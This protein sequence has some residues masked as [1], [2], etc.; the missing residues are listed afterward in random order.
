[1]RSARFLALAI[2]LASSLFA[3]VAASTEGTVAAGRPWQPG[4]SLCV[5]LGPGDF[6]P[7]AG[8]AIAAPEDNDDGAG[9]HYCLYTP[10]R[11][12]IKGGIEFDAFVGA[13][14]ETTYATVI[15]ETGRGVD[16]RLPGADASSITLS[17]RVT[18][19]IAVRRGALVFAISLPQSAQAETELRRLAVLVL[20]RAAKAIAG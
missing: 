16:A 9:G 8:L 14:P 19:S 18:T 13:D 10:G 11:Y 15:G 4:E 3:A 20:S 6:T 7:I 5:M 12:P 17:D 1:M 2:A